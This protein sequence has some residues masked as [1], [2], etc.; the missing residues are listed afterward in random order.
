[1]TD[2]YQKMTIGI[3]R[4]SGEMKQEYFFNHLPAS[5]LPKQNTTSP[6]TDN[7]F[8][9]SKRIFC[10]SQHAVAAFETLNKCKSPHLL[11]QWRAQGARCHHL[12]Q[13]PEDF[14]SDWCQLRHQEQRHPENSC[15]PRQ[16]GR[17]PHC[18]SSGDW[19]LTLQKELELGLTYHPEDLIQRG[20]S[21]DPP[22][23]D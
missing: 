7:Q 23:C 4:N 10:S 15:T 6:N 12:H 22:V 5:V 14:D 3:T 20:P 16:W 1:M 13:R 9:K 19:P 11:L 2:N 18:C 8:C 17:H 21:A